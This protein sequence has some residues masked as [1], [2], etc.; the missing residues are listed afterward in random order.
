MGQTRVT[1]E[2]RHIKG[3]RKLWEHLFLVDTGATDC[4]IPR[5]AL[6]KLGVEVEGQVDSELADGTVRVF[7]Y[8]FVRVKFMGQETV[9]HAVFGPDEAEP[10]LGVVALENTGIAVDPKTHSL[11]RLHAKPLKTRSRKSA[12]SDRGSP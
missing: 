2:V 8:G 9:C 10:L 4:F 3:G 7:D 12:R 1:V 6:T 5:S 11:K